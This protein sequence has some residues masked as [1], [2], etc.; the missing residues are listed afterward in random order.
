L[1]ASGCLQLV[2]NSAAH[3]ALNLLHFITLLSFYRISPLAQDKCENH[4]EGSP[5]INKSI[6]LVNFLTSALFFIPFTLFYSIFF[7]Y[8]LSLVALLVSK[9]QTDLSII[10]LLF[11][12]T[13]C[14]LISHIAYH[15]T[16][17]PSTPTLN[18]P[19]SDLSTTFILEQ[20]LKPISS[21][22]LLLRSLCSPIGYLRLDI[23][24]IDQA[25]YF[26]SCSFRYIIHHHYIHPIL[27]YLT[28]I[29]ISMTNLFTF[30]GN[31]CTI[32]IYIY[33]C[34]CVCVCV[35][36]QKIFLLLLNSASCPQPQVNKIIAM[37][38]KH[39]NLQPFAGLSR[40]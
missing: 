24:G 33:M 31:I 9:L 10:L 19:V 23:S 20:Q 11:C 16:P 14:R 4:V 21:I 29:F 40:M 37:Q 26:I 15:I 39:V 6:K 2:I 22:N 18:S 34:V 35:C 12:G 27:L 30:L 3:V 1:N 28:R 8:H 13:V 25:S 17:S 38:S 7:S 5:S 32:Y 36:L